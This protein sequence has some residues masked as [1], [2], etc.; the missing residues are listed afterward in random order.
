MVVGKTVE[1][2]TSRLA[3]VLSDLQEA[4]GKDGKPADMA[5]IV[6]DETRLL[7]RQITR[8]V[9]PQTQAIGERAISRELKSLFTAVDQEMIDTIGSEYGL[10]NIDQWITTISGKKI[11][12]RWDAIDPTGERMPERHNKARDSRGKIRKGPWPHPPEWRARVVVSKEDRAAYAAK[13]MKKVGLWKASWAKILAD[14]ADG[15]AKIAGWINRHIEDGTAAKI[16]LANAMG[17]QNGTS[18]SVQFGSRAP[19]VMRTADKVRDAARVRG[20]AIKKKVRLILSGYAKD[21]SQG[22]R[23]QARAKR[24]GRGGNYAIG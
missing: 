19:G 7:V 9:P 11:R 20:E 2:D 10:T 1:V 22:M 6:A 8:F 12:L 15:K 14:M 21:V 5:E 16:S 4:L 3:E 13:T 23:I 24:S 18:P 17:L